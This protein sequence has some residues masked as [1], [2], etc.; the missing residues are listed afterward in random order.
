MSGNNAGLQTLLSEHVGRL[1]F[2]IHC[3]CHKLGLVVRDSLSS[4]PYIDDHYDTVSALNKHF[5]SLRR[6]CVET[7]D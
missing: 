1:I 3:F 2:Y 4:I 7:I 6:S 5:E